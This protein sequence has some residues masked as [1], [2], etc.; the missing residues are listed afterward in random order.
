MI[1]LFPSRRGKAKK[2]GKERKEKS[3]T[4]QKETRSGSAMVAAASENFL[5][6]TWISNGCSQSSATCNDSLSPLC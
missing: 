6:Q 2:R 3:E 5:G 1:S 4:T